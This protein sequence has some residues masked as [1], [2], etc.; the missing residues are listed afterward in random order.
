VGVDRVEQL[1]DPL[2]AHGDRP[3]QR[4]CPVVL[5]LRPD[6]V[7]ELEHAAQLGL[8]APRTR[9]VGL[10]HDED[11]GDLE[12]AGLRGLDAVPEPGREHEQRRVG[13]RCDVDL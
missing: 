7:P 12:D 4:R 11:V 6:D 2:A 1:V 3:E 13:E 8:E 5:G 10:V 9:L